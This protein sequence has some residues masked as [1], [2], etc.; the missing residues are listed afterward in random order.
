MSTN[1]LRESRPD[2]IPIRN[3]TLI[4]RDQIGCLPS[5]TNRFTDPRKRKARFDSGGSFEK[6]LSVRLQAPPMPDTTSSAARSA[7]LHRD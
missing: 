6:P 1:H 7:M 3:L 5:R 4:T 2:F